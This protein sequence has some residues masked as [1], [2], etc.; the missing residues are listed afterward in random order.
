MRVAASEMRRMR[1]EARSQE[2]VSRSLTPV[3]MLPR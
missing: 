1:V 2:R 3:R